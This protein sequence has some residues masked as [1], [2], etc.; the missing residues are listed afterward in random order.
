MARRPLRSPP[1]FA[2]VLILV[3][4][5]RRRLLLH[6]ARHRSVSRTSISRRSSS[7]RVCPAPRPSRSRPRSPT[8]SRRRS[9]PSAASTR[10]RSTSSEG[11]SQVVVALHA[12]E[13]RRRRHAGGARQ[14]QP[15]PA[16]ACRERIDAADDREARSR[17]RAGAAPSRSP[18]NKP[19][20]DITEYADKVLRRQLESAD[21]VG[22]VLVLGGRERQVNVWLDAEQLRAHEPDRRRRVARAAGAEQRRAGRPHRAGRAG[23]HAAHARARRVARRSSATSS[24]GRSDGHPVRVRDVA[25]IE[26]G[27]ADAETLA[28]VNGDPTVLLQIRKQSG[29][30]TVAIVERG[31]G[32]PR[33]ASSERFHPA[34]QLRDR[35]R[36]GASSSKPR[37]TACKEHLVVGS[38]LAALVVLLFL[39]NLRSHDHRRDRRFRPRSSPRSA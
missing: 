29:M 36:P 13:G 31:E 28:S 5:G 30:N 39:G 35:A 33:R 34:Y 16:A 22:Q 8:R 24:S 21:G 9:T 19:L 2:S 32:A 23:D 6:P 15:R 37:S 18:P 25:R 3:A 14:G 10:S 7:R 1:V 38:V 27:M 4:D 12:R 26:D 17:T 11:V 20:R